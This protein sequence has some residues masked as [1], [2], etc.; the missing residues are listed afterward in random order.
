METSYKTIFDRFSIYLLA[1]FVSPLLFGA[2]MALYSMI[3]FQDSWSFG[4]TV[5]VVAL[6][7]WPFFGFG[8]FPV[9]L[10]IDFSARMK[11]Y[12]NWVKA[13][14][15]VVSG[16]VAGLVANVIL[17]GLYPMI[18]MFLFGMVGGVIHFIVLELIKKFIK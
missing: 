3:A 11:N 6:Y 5:L 9:S 17:N 2:F 15:F 10:Y 7:S 16:G 12:P 18:F 8:A 13:L 1:I 14:L 4:P